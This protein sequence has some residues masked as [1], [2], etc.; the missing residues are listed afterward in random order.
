M[1]SA[2][3]LENLPPYLFVEID[4]KIKAARKKGVDIIS[5]GIGDPDTPTPQHII[6]ACISAFRDPS[7]HQ[8][9]SSVG[10]S[11]FREGVAHRYEEDYNISVDP[12]KTVTSLIGSKEGIHNIHLAY[13]NPGDVVLYPDPGYPVYHISPEFCG[14]RAVKMPLVKENN[15]LPDLEAISDDAAKKAKI[16]WLNYPNN[17]TASVAPNEFYKEVLDFAKQHNIIVCSDEAYASIAYD[18]YVPPSLMEFDG[19]WERGI[20]FGSLSKT[21]N[22]T[23]W[24]VG[25]AL[26]CED[27]V[28]SLVKLK[29]NVDSG[30]PQFIQEAG[31]VALTSSQECVRKMVKLY[32]ERRDL[33]VN[34]LRKLGFTV[35]KPKAT[36]YLWMEVPDGDSMSFASRMLEHGI[37][38]TPGVG[39]GENG[40]GYVRFA[41]TQNQKRVG[42]A[43]ERMEGAL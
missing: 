42:E 34:G 6:D 39:F 16:I 11:T 36:F 27:V 24:R 37:V 26:G 18:G 14:G 9:P 29:G 7:N 41:L 40:E 5:F 38:V 35:E 32:E 17:P 23:G 3:R 8:Y 12:E 25:Y 30:T 33:L 4:E 2:D 10:M 13:I 1:R 20:V 28:K 15:F 43:L 22:M 31:R 19:A 21:Y